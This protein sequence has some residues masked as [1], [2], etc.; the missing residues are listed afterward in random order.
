MSSSRLL[1]CILFLLLSSS[2][3][4]F[5][6]QENDLQSWTMTGV[7]KKLGSNYLA[8]LTIISRVNDNISRFNDASFNWKLSVSLIMDYLH[9]WFLGIGRSQKIKL[10]I[11]FAT[12]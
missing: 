4:L 12:I 6:A 1:C 3:Y 7:S 2:L 5:E 10:Y 11:F 8:S 9:K